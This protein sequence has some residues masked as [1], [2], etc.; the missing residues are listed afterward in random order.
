LFYK[1]S[2]QQSFRISEEDSGAFYFLFVIGGFYRSARESR[3]YFGTP[4]LGAY[5]NC[6][7]R[8]SGHS[9]S[10]FTEKGLKEA[11]RG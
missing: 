6:P 5:R 9:N 4:L 3:K 2:H 1:E 8:H 10:G 7:L 11:I